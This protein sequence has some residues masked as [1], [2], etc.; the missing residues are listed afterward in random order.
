MRAGALAAGILR[1]DGTRTELRL[2]P[3]PGSPGVY[4][5]DWIPPRPGTYRVTL[6]APSGGAVAETGFVV[7]AE[8]LELQ[9]PE[10]NRDLLQRVAQASGGAYL[11]LVDLDRLPGG[12]PDRSELRV[13]RTERP[14]WDTPLPLAVFSF[15]LVGEWV[16]RKRAGLL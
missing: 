13:T 9:E 1:D 6:R 7:R 15:F 5:T 16:L 10:M 4:S 12:I 3:A 11:E 8:P 14:L 2:S